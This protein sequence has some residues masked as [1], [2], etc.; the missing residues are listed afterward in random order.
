MSTVRRGPAQFDG[1]PDRRSS[2]SN[3]LP[4]GLHR[5]LASYH[6]DLGR[7]RRPLVHCRIEARV[8]SVVW[9]GLPDVCLRSVRHYSRVI[10]R[11]LDWSRSTG[12]VL[13]D[14]WSHSA[15]FRCVA[16]N[17]WSGTSHRLEHAVRRQGVGCQSFA[18]DRPRTTR[19]VPA[20]CSPT[21]DCWC[22]VSDERA[23]GDRCN[24]WAVRR[25]VRGV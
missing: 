11:L 16:S 24:E 3:R 4:T 8:V 9:C 7:C 13:P 18:A 6:D 10:Q 12:R 5:M 25:L 14:E 2:D 21:V 23:K 17:E 1:A 19:A 22:T 15:V 20:D